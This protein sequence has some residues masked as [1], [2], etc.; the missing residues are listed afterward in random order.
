MCL[1]GQPVSAGS[2]GEGRHFP[3]R[4]QLVF[5]KAPEPDLAGEAVAG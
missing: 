5:L 1:P 2:A 3:V 4:K